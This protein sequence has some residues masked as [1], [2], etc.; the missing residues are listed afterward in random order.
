MKYYVTSFWRPGILATTQE[1]MRE[2]TNGI[3][4]LTEDSPTRVVK[5]MEC[6][7]KHQ[8]LQDACTRCRTER[9]DAHD[10]EVQSSRYFNHLEWR[11]SEWG[12]S[13]WF[14]PVFLIWSL[15][16][17]EFLQIFSG[18]RYFD[19]LVP[20]PGENLVNG[21]GPMWYGPWT[22][23]LHLEPQWPE[24]SRDPRKTSFGFRKTILICSNLPNKTSRVW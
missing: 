10:Y 14:Q 5:Q 11:D 15:V 17:S 3:I 12:D 9:L 22:R 20:G 19:S 18:F 21:P 6:V 7:S 13:P 2:V 23:D 8:C 24:V 1:M 16:P 4:K